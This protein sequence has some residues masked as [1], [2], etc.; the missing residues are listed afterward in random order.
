MPGK[1]VTHSE[2]QRALK[3]LRKE[4]SGL[5]VVSSIKAPGPLQAQSESYPDETYAG[6]N[7]RDADYTDT[8]SRWGTFVYKVLPKFNQNMRVFA[9]ICITVDVSTSQDIVLRLRNGPTGYNESGTGRG[10]VMR[11]DAPAGDAIPMACF[12]FF[13]LEAGLDD[14]DD[15]R[16]C[17][18]IKK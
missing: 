12:A 17:A 11:E 2:L 4:I 5:K 9:A 14:A 3:N 16:I 15:R 6:K 1:F 7:E 18:D 8:D 13:D 10:K